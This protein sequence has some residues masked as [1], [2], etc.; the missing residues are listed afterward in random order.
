MK[1]GFRLCAI[2]IKRFLKN[3]IAATKLFNGLSLLPCTVQ[4]SLSDICNFKCQMCWVHSALVKSSINP[5]HRLFSAHSPQILSYDNFV[6]IVDGLYEAKI[7]E[8]NLVGKG[9]PLLNPLLIQMCKYLDYRK[10]NF[11]ICTNGSLLTQNLSDNLLNTNINYIC[12]SLNAAD[13]QTYNSVNCP[14]DEISFS[15]VMENIN[16]LKEKKDKINSKMKISL[17]FVISKLNVNSVMDMIY[18]SQ[19]FTDEAELSPAIVYDE[20]KHLAIDRNDYVKLEKLLRPVAD[21]KNIPQF[22]G[23]IDFFTRNKDLRYWAKEFFCHNPCRVPFTFAVI[24]ADGRVT[25]CCPTAYVCGN[26][27]DEKFKKIWNSYKFRFF[28]KCA[29]N[30][31]NRKEEA[32]MSYC[33]CCDQGIS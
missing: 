14:P 33:Y 31:S 5:E 26:A 9:E 24:H 13:E 32:P 21:I 19:R 23:K 2:S 8:V 12:I 22:L 10:M 18:L 28:R 7:R 11:G 20:I 4:L 6:K 1:M 29:L 16:H 25:P 15:T 30:L 17:S 3:R 27:I